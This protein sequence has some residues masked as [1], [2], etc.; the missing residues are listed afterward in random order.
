M[1]SFRFY[2]SDLLFILLF[3]NFLIYNFYS[4]LYYLRLL[5]QITFYYLT[6]LFFNLYTKKYLNATIKYNILY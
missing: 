2:Y 3:I 1:I 6:I 4:I 5:N